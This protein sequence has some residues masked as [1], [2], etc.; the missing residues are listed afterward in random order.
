[1]GIRTS[2]RGGRA[3]SIFYPVANRG[4]W[5]PTLDRPQD[6]VFRAAD[7]RVRY[8]LGGAGVGGEDLGGG[9][10][11]LV[12][13]E[14]RVVIHTLPGRI[15]EHHV[16]WEFGRDD[17]SA[18]VDGVCYR[19]AAKPFDFRRGPDVMLAAGIELLSSNEA[20]AKQSPTLTAGE[21]GRKTAQWRIP[22]GETLAVTVR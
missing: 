2:Q 8:E 21:I 12:A 19:G 9:K 11:A 4:D 15:G 1:M 20:P 18:Y 3:L 16:V 13:G 10:F 14:H 7:F 6:G 5:H 17:G 22:S